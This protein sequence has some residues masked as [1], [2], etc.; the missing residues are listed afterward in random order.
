M[1]LSIIVPV[2]KVEQTLERCVDSI[3]HQT[4]HQWEMI[5]VDDGS[6]DNC[7]SICN[8]YAMKDYRIRVIHQPNSGL[9]AARNAGIKIATGEYITFVDSDDYVCKDTF[10]QLM[11]IVSTQPDIDILEYPMTQIYKHSKRCK[12]LNFIP[13]KYHDMLNYWLIGKAYLHT[14]AWNKIYKRTLFGQVSYPINTV[15]EDVHTLPLLLKLCKC[16]ATTNKGLYYY[17]NNPQGITAM[18]Q[19]KEL[20]QLLQA[21]IDVL[22]NPEL[23]YRKGFVTYYAH[24]LN[25]Q[26]DVYEQTGDIPILPP[27]HRNEEKNIPIKIKLLNLIGLQHLCQLNQFIHKV[28]RRS[29]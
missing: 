2:Y 22:K 6:P 11:N 23:A 20:N 14:Y 18:A 8:R 21:H 13:Q 19:G 12:Q 26:L 5:L 17:C 28:Y 25:I 16:V 15:F 1:L 27:F 7:P 4:Y 29:H 9:S 3:L 24:V 10:L